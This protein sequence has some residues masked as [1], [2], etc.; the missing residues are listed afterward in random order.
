MSSETNSSKAK[1]SGSSDR[2]NRQRS[3]D[4]HH[5]YAALCRSK[6]IQPLPEI[7]KPKQKGRALLDVYGDRFKGYD[8]ELIVDALREDRSLRFMAL[9][10]RKTYTEGSACLLSQRCGEGGGMEKPSSLD[11]RMYKQLLDT[12]AVF[13]RTN[14]VVETFIV[15]GLPMAGMRL[16]TLVTGLHQNTS[17]TELNLA[18]CSIGDEGCEQLCSEVKFLPNL[19]VLNL[20]ACQLTSKACQSIADVIKFQK[21]QRYATSWEMSLRY[22]DIK[23]DKLLGLRY[24]YLSHNPAIGDEG[25]LQ[26]TDV[27]KEDAWVLQVHVCNCGLTDSGAQF[28]IECLNLNNTIEKFDIT[29]NTNI[30]NE[31]CL[32]I[33]VKLGAKL[34]DDNSDSSLPGSAKSSKTL[35][36]LRE[37]SEY[38]ELQ[39]DTERNRNTQL[40]SMVEQLQLQIGDYAEKRNEL[41]RELSVLIKAR[42]DLLDKVK[43]L[44]ST[45]SKKSGIL[46][47]SHSESFVQSNQHTLEQLV[48]TISK[49]VAVVQLGESGEQP[50]QAD[51]APTRRVIERSIGDG[52]DGVEKAE[53]PNLE[54][55][56]CH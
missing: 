6:N 51:A 39:L 37:H 22:G 24:L 41:S 15:E 30:S 29:D 45:S 28:L 40:E 4:F 36:G 11:K 8:W 16:G 7:V 42:N 23:E 9:R 18:R 54:K 3:K 19:Q 55:K 2:R 21:L 48:A 25:L 46:R 33:L 38:L 43:K 26:L 34:E 47:K 27:L 35:A 5:R 32:E 1:A 50:Q 31:A 53:D 52:G 17:L 10:M 56:L 49:S 12:L 14:K 13:L 20:T 44:E